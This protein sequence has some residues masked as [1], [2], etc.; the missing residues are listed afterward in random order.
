MIRK[1][2]GKEINR[3]VCERP[4]EMVK[5]EISIPIYFEAL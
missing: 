2:D 5:D 1:Y 3:E 4:R